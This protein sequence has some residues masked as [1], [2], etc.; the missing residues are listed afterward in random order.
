M[1]VIARRDRT[2][3]TNDLIET[4][5]AGGAAECGRILTQLVTFP[6]PTT[7]DNARCQTIVTLSLGAM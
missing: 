4:R 1:R 3:G 7:T 2:T 6:I 5:I